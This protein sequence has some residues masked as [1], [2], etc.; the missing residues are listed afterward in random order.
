MSEALS[1]ESDVSVLH[2]HVDSSVQSDTS[3]SSMHTDSDDSNGSNE[4]ENTIR[5]TF[6]TLQLI[7]EDLTEMLA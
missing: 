5:K 3:L 2:E 7:I 6:L 4:S 1:S